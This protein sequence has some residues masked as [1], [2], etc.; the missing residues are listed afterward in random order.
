V[1][2]S[3]SDYNPINK[4]SEFYEKLTMFAY[5]GSSLTLMGL[6]KYDKNANNG[7]GGFIMTEVGGFLAGGL[8][9]CKK[10][11]NN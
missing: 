3:A 10:L 4:R 7:Q 9:E 11:I 6:V 5:E 8:K 2:K 1:R